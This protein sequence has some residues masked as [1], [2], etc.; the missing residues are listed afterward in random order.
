MEI[1]C[2]DNDNIRAFCTHQT[3]ESNVRDFLETFLGLLG[4][5][6]NCIHVVGFNI[7][8]LNFNRLDG[9]RVCRWIFKKW[10][11]WY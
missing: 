1:K 4:Q 10:A 7:N 8:L 2:Y 5:Y 9:G 3:P 11:T 6:K